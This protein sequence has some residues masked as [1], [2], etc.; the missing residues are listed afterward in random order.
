MSN[1]YV[2]QRYAVN[3]TTSRGAPTNR[4]SYNWQYTSGE[5]DESAYVFYGDPDG[6]EPYISF[7]HSGTG[8]V[9]DRYDSGYLSQVIAYGGS[10]SVPAGKYFGFSSVDNGHTYNVYLTTAQ[11][12]VEGGGRTAQSVSPSVIPLTFT[13][14]KG[15]ANGTVSNSAASTY[16]P[17]DY[18]SKS[19]RI[20]PYSAPGMRGSG[21]VS[22]SMYPLLGAALTM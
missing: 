11:T 14:A 13:E 5:P 20:W 3:I 6:G 21:R 18:P 4:V 2:W 16:P 17:R 12:E 1:R 9:F 22:T 15:S 19:A 8:F 10:V 7:G